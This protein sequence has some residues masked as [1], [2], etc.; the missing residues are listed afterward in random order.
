MKRIIK[1]VDDI[2]NNNEKCPLPL[3][4]IP[5][6]MGI[7]LCSVDSISW[8]EYDD[9]ELD[10]LTIHF[11]PTVYKCEKCKD[12]GSR[13]SEPFEKYIQCDCEAGKKFIK[14]YDKF[15]RELNEDDYVD[16]QKD[17]AQKIYK[18]EDGQLYF[19]P[20]GKEDRVSA[21]FANDLV[22]CDEN[23]EWL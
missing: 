14:C 8:N 13:Y 1:K 7:N 19:K 4:V 18:K 15:K 17:G 22:K 20:Y 5:N 10:N 2:I 16:V 6:Y 21:Y 9:G 12:S 3:H 23:G 11:I